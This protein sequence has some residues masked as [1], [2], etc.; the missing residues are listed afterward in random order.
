MRGK[1]TLVSSL[2]RIAYHPYQLITQ[3]MTFEMNTAG[4]QEGWAVTVTGAF[5]GSIGCVPNLQYIASIN[6]N[7]RDTQPSCSSFSSRRSHFPDWV[8]IDQPSSLQTNSTG[9]FHTEARFIDS[10]SM[11]D[12]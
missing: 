7:S 4:V 6:L 5:N 9:K 2:E 10:S 11:P 3:K 8:V 12:S 1:A